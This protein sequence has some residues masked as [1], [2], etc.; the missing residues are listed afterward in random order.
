L[1]QPGRQGRYTTEYFTVRIDNVPAETPGD[2]IRSGCERR[3][4]WF[5]REHHYHK[6]I[7]RALR[8]FN[9]LFAFADKPDV[10]D[11]PPART[12]LAQS[13]TTAN[14]NDTCLSGHCQAWRLQGPN[15]NA[16]RFNFNQ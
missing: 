6:A 3:H 5:T 12:L 14:I 9:P 10:G 8:T 16:I 15:I 2:P 11:F 13:Q 4:S 1:E 7:Q